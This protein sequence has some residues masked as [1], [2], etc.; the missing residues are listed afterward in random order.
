M[1]NWKVM[2]SMP[3]NNAMLLVTSASGDVLKARLPL[4][5]RHPRA[6]VTLLEGLSMWSGS[7]VCAVISAGRR[8]HPLCGAAVFGPDAWPTE[9]P[10]VSWVVADDAR[11]ARITGVGDFRELYAARAR[12]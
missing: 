8:S 12:S 7:P 4:P 9:S 6:A 11:H 5:A 2:L 1:E 3:R 10:L